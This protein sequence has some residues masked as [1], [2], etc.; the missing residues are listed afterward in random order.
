MLCALD[1]ICLLVHD[2]E[3]AARD[4]SALFGCTPISQPSQA[5]RNCISFRLSNVKLDLLNV[6]EQQVDNTIGEIVFA[7]DDL[8][9]AKH[10]L[11]RRGIASELRA[12]E[13]ELATAATHGVSIVLVERPA[14]DSTQANANAQVRGLDHIVI[15]TSHPER[16][17]ALYGARLGLELKLDRTN[18]DWGSRLLFFKCGDLI[19]EI[20]HS[21]KK[22]DP[23]TPDKAWGLSWRVDDINAAHR[24]L[25]KANFSVSEIRQGRKPG[26]KVFTVRE[27]TAGVPT[28]IIGRNGAVA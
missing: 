3:S 22:S 27:R 28:L 25:T 10:V 1:R 7:T 12:T 8:A 23:L 20:A 5:D 24:H 26:T 15:T 19:V 21:L 2:L 6:G 11:E 17:A 16:A 9:R 18:T 13:L 4:Y 14:G